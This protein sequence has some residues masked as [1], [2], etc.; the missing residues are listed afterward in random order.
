MS[1]KINSTRVENETLWTNV[2]LVLADSTE[3]TMDVPHFM[4]SDSD[5][6]LQGIANREASEQAKYDA[7]QNMQK[8]KDAVDS[9]AG[10]SFDTVHGAP[11]KRS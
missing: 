10:V 3:L 5:Y 9:C 7:I 11:I 1:F 6:V 4:A 8:V 2:T